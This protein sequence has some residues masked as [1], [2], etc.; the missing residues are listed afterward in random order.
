MKAKLKGD[1]ITH[2]L[3][4][5]NDLSVKEK[6][7]LIEHVFSNEEVECNDNIDKFISSFQMVIEIL[8]LKE[9]CSI[10]Q[11]R[12]KFLEKG[13]Q[14]LIVEILIEYIL[15]YADYLLN[16]PKLK[17]INKDDMVTICNFVM[18][19]FIL[20]DNF[21]EIKPSD[22]IKTLTESNGNYIQSTFDFI[23]RA[24]ND[25]SLRVI[26]PEI[27]KNKL[28][29]YYFFNKDIVKIIMEPID[30]NVDGMQLASMQKN[31]SKLVN[32]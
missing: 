19:N 15:R 10:E 5:Y 20:Y 23:I 29:N 31:I 13:F 4:Q 28:E 26:S 21:I 18:N 16:I 30:G 17:A 22:F 8:I 11:T 7:V 1:N 12:E 24:Y 3:N 32:D 9:N 2:L 6:L 27:L 14:D 25:I